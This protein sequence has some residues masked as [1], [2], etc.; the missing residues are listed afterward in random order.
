MSKKD[1]KSIKYILDELD[2][3]EKI[4]FERELK[5]DPD[6]IIEVESIRRMQNKIEYLPEFQ[7]PAELSESIL[8]LAAERSSKSSG[9]NYRLFLSAAILLFGLTTGTLLIENP[10][11]SDNSHSQASMHLNS[12]VLESNY[13]NPAVLNRSHS[14]WVDRNEVLRIGAMESGTHQSRL[15]EMSE[16]ANKLRPA[17]NSFY[18]EPVTRSLQLT[19]SNPRR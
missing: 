15:S 12:S 14:P 13:Q 17:E 19:G 8:N 4:E 7:P 10:F 18:R 9:S 3:A 5:N 2:P 11:S 16:S 1:T 6:L